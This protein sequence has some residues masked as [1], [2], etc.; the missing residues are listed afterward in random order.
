MDKNE[1]TKFINP[2]N[3]SSNSD[4][5]KKSQVFKVEPAKPKTPA[6]KKDK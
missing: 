2:H 4:I 3:N 6:I 5:H 1:N